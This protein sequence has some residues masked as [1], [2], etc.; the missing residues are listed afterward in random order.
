[1]D[2]ALAQ[3][4]NICEPVSYEEAM[5]SKEWQKALEEEIS[6]LKVNHTWDLV[7]KLEEVKPISCRWVYKVK[8]RVDGS[9]ERYKG[10]LLACG[11]SQQYGIDYYETFN[12]ITKITIVRAF[13]ASATSK[14]SRGYGRWM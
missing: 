9:I 6:A 10:R 4:S 3:T 8:T 2:G 13:L 5:Q 1:M 12:P 14:S 11:F 7:P